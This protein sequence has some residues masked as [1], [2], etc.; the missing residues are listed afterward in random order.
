MSDLCYRSSLYSSC[1]NQVLPQPIT[2]M[3]AA[4]RH[5]Q[6]YCEATAKVVSLPSRESYGR[7]AAQNKRHRP[8][9][10]RYVTG[11]VLACRSTKMLGTQWEH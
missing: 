10:P 6:W 9:G 3:F 1:Q 5:R 8:W 11:V 2:N 7:N 4:V